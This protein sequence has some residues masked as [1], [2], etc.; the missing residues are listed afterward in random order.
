MTDAAS[1]ETFTGAVPA[2]SFEAWADA[3]L[4]GLSDGPLQQSLLAGGSSNLVLRISRG[5]RPM[6]LR[7]PPLALRPDSHK[8]IA[9]EARVLEAL[10]GS[11]VPAPRFEAYC[12]DP[13]VIGAPFYV[14]AL[15]DGFLGY[16]FDAL[17]APYDRPGE[18]KR[19]LAFAL[20]DALAELAKVDYRAVGLEGFGKPEG[21]LERQVSRWL[22]Q[23]E[24]YRET[25][26]YAQRDLPGLAYVVDWLKDN[27]PAMSPPGILH[28]DYSFANCIFAHGEPARVAAMIDWELAT[29]GDPLLDLGL[30]LYPFRG[31]DERTPPA[32][33]FDAADFPFRE[34]L[35]ERWAERSGRPV[36]NLTYYMVLVQF[37]MAVILERQH[38][39]VLNGKQPKALGGFAETFVP[40]LI[41]KADAMARGTA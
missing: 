9:R 40:G 5:G 11:T 8:V 17:P 14:M 3:N 25:E 19:Q 38:A 4:P 2:T 28:G 32:G 29:V 18:P 31:R 13:S 15:V 1:A 36:E 23:L 26:D 10:N 30:V 12:E 22:S 33:Y 20:V 37:K 27:T 34:E 16:P 41:A 21:F 7:R 6:I 24:S 39:R 35:A